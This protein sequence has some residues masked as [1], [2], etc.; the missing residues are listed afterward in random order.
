[1]QREGTLGARSA[2]VAD[3]EQEMQQIGEGG[4]IREVVLIARTTKW[5]ASSA[6]Y[7]YGKPCRTPHT[8]NPNPT[9]STAASAA[10]ARRRLAR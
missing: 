4:R 3:Q 8:R 10:H 5:S 2:S 1:M 7:A 9:T 6:L